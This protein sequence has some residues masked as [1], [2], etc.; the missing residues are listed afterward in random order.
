MTATGREL[1]HGGIQRGTTEPIGSN[2][3]PWRR[4]V[5][6]L[7]ADSL[8]ATTGATEAGPFS[9]MPQFR[10]MDGAVRN[11]LVFGER[12]ATYSR[13]TKLVPTA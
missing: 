2:L 10:D 3:P 11:H 4:S 8:P 7:Q 1:A 12:G 13:E 6:E 5:C 9:E